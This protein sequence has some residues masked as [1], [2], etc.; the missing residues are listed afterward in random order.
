MLGMH[1]ETCFKLKGFV[2]SYENT[3]V[4]NCLEPKIKLN[5]V[6]SVFVS[7]NMMVDRFSKSFTTYITT[8]LACDFFKKKALPTPLSK[9]HVVMAVYML[10]W[11]ISIST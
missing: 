8:L 1:T 5:F 7:N 2:H 9:V 6:L 10:K 3:S 4:L 11:Q